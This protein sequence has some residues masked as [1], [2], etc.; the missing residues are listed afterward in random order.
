VHVKDK[1]WW[2]LVPVVVLC[3]LAAGFYFTHRVHESEDIVPAP[4]APAEKTPEAPSIQH[5]VPATASDTPLPQL[6]DS[7]RPFLQS[8][9]NLLGDNPVQQLFV[10]TQIVRH[11]V[12]TIDNLP[13]KKVAPQTLPI[14]PVAGAFAANDANGKLTLSSQN[15]A[16]YS[17]WVKLAESVDTQQLAALYFR[18]YPLFQEAYRNLGYPDGYF[19]DRLVQVIDDALAAPQ[20]EGPIELLQ[21]GVMYQYANPDLEARSAGQKVLMRMGSEN[22]AKVKRKLREL[23]AAITQGEPSR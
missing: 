8:L 15:A 21:P 22:E 13:R 3:G 20:I 9:A 5:P 16:R 14:K 19:N 2:W 4:A 11:I 6:D 12:A 10:P 1:L 17:T 18:Y 23:R 7:D